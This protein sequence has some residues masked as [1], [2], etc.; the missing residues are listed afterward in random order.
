MTELLK[1]DMWQEV[2]NTSSTSALR[3]DAPAFVPAPPSTI[4]TDSPEAELQQTTEVKEIGQ[5][6][7]SLVQ[8]SLLEDKPEEAERDVQVPEIEVKLPEDTKIPA[9]HAKVVRVKIVN[10]EQVKK[11]LVNMLIPRRNTLLEEG[12]VVTNSLV[13]SDPEGCFKII[14]ENHS[15]NSVHLSRGQDV[16]VLELVTL[17]PMEGISSV[18]DLQLRADGTEESVL[19][20]NVQPRVDTLIKEIPIN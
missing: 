2:E 13:Q 19:L 17:I 18:Q 1:G 12:I 10:P 3:A 14:M 11:I 16:G 15:L 5:N 6:G 20:C 8:H 7:A 9:R 4:T